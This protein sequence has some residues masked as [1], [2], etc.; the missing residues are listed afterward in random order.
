MSP[1]GKH[2]LDIQGFLAEE[3]KQ[4]DAESSLR[5]RAVAMEKKPCG[6]FEYRRCRRMIF[7]EGWGSVRRGAIRS[8]LGTASHRDGTRVGDFRCG[9]RQVVPATAGA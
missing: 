6:T 4:L 1:S 3:D 9:P 8:N 5:R 2:F 7:V